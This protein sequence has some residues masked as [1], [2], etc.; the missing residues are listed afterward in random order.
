[1]RGNSPTKLADERVGTASGNRR[2]RADV[3]TVRNDVFY[4]CRGL[5]RWRTGAA[6]YLG[7]VFVSAPALACEASSVTSNATMSTSRPVVGSLCDRVDLRKLRIAHV[8]SPASMF[9]P[10]PVPSRSR[11]YWAEVGAAAPDRGAHAST[12]AVDVE[13][14]PTPTRLRAATLK[15]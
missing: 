7:V 6:S 13:S 12:D 4:A 15:V 8:V 2:R 5:P 11:L 3:E 9:G 10:H 14:T 1:L